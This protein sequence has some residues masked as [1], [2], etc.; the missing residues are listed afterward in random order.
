VAVGELSFAVSVPRS[1]STIQLPNG[2]TLRREFKF[3][4]LNITPGFYSQTASVLV[5]DSDLIVRAEDGRE[6]FSLRFAVGYGC[7][8]SLYFSKKPEGGLA[9]SPLEAGN[10]EFTL[11]EFFNALN[12]K[13]QSLVPVGYATS[14]VFFDWVDLKW[15]NSDKGQ[16]E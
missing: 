11:Q 2:D 7:M 12:A 1:W 9:E 5:I 14:P 3:T 13:F 15:Y 16:P 10:F 6:D 4:K 8:E